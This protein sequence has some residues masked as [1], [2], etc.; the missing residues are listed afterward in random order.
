MSLFRR[1]PIVA[2]LNLHGMISAT[3]STSVTISIHNL[4]KHIDTAFNTANTVAVVLSINSPGGSPVQSELIYKKIRNMATKKKIP[5]L[6]FIEDVGASGGY[7]LACAGDEIY[8]SKSSIV[9]SIGVIASGFGFKDFIAKH[10]IERRVFTQGQNKNI[11][12]PFKEIK[13]TDVNILNAVSNDLHKNFIDIVKTSRKNKID[14]NNN[15]LFS[16]IFYSGGTAKQHGL[17]DGT[18]NMYELIESKFG[19]DVEIKIVKEKRRGHL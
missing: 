2:I 1:K 8:A 17:I 7:M 18:D 9:G 6:S 16:G 4:N 12:D 15:E 19:A 13:D 10:G 14:P 3:K 5:V 11:L